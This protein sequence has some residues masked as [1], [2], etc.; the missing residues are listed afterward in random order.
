MPGRHSPFI[1]LHG[2]A[3]QNWLKRKET[4][5][6][7]GY[8][9]RPITGRLKCGCLRA[10]ALFYTDGI[11][12]AMNEQEEIFGF[13]RLLEIVQSGA[14]L[15]AEELHREILDKVSD[16]AGTAA[17]HDDLTV[18]VVKAVTEES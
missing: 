15:T 5:F 11:V 7:W 6:R 10:I 12:E 18:I 13:E 17:Q 9:M 1:C 16:F 2:M 3:R 4:P 8:W 14:S